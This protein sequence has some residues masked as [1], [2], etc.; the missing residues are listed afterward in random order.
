VYA[1]LIAG[2]DKEARDKIDATLAWPIDEA[3]LR[4]N[5]GMGPEAEAG[6]RAMMAMATMRGGR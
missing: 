4:A 1:Y 3:E 5:W 6:Q 2:A